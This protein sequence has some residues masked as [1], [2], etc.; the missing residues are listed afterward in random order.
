[1]DQQFYYASRRH[2]RRKEAML[3]NGSLCQAVLLKFFSMFLFIGI[4]LVFYV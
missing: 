4:F 2:F 3:N 1:M